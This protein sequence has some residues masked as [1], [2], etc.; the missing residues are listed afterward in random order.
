MSDDDDV[1][2]VAR[3]LPPPASPVDRP[4]DADWAAAERDIGRSVPSDYRA[5]VERY[6]S[7]RIDGFLHVL[8][9]AA[10]REPLRLVPA[11]ERLLAGLRTIRESLPDEAPYPLHPEPGGLLPWAFTDNG[12]VFFWSTEA[13][14]PARWSIVISES[15]GPG[16]AAHPGPTTRF[17]AELFTRAYRPPFLPGSWPSDRP[18]FEPSGLP[19]QWERLHR[20]LPPPERPVNVAGLEARESIEASLGLRLPADYWWFQGTFG[21]G[22]MGGDLQVFAPAELAEG[23]R[24]F[25]EQLELVNTRRPGEVPFVVR[26]EPGGLLAWGG[27]LAGVM[28]FWLT[29]GPTRTGGRSLFATRPDRSG[30][31]TR[32]R[33]PGSSPT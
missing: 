2:E 29:P 26:P 8:N 4:G 20:L 25:A 16:W 28:G 21:A 6:G 11:V 18:T 17:L 23:H 1:A 32:V 30:S 9:P 24:R 22:S 12:D 13:A 19:L 15:G 27:T 10:S 7:G 14:D 33:W 3:L 5:L 31:P